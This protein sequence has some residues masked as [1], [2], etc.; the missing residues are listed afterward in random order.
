ME[1]A[2]GV[3]TER[4]TKVSGPNGVGLTTG[5]QF[6]PTVL[7]WATSIENVFGEKEMTLRR[8]KKGTRAKAIIRLNSLVP[9]KLC[10]IFHLSLK[11]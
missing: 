6:V 2:V 4:A 10:K 11:Q 8:R 1:M 5:C 3:I 7:R 9:P